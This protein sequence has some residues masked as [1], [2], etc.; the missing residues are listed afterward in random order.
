MMVNNDRRMVDVPVTFSHMAA[1]PFPYPSD[2]ILIFEEWFYAML[3]KGEERHRIYLPIFWTG[4]YI[5]AD[6]GKNEALIQMLQDY[7]NILDKSKKYYTIVQYDDGI[8][9]DLSGLDIRVFAMSGR[10]IDYPLPMICQPHEYKFNVERDIF[11]SFVG[12][13]T[14]TLREKIIAEFEDRPACYVTSR[15]HTLKDYCHVMARSVF[16][17]CPRGYGPTSFRIME[18]LQYGAIPV[19]M[20]DLL[21][22][23]HHH[24]F[25]GVGIP[26]TDEFN[27]R[28]LLSALRNMPISMERLRTD[29]PTIFQKCYTYEGTKAL[30]LENL[31]H[32]NIGN[33]IVS[34]N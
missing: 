25:P 29:I 1:H 22:F 23:G 30:I 21:I 24:Q 10:R 16:A 27:P 4:Y 11:M 31:Y 15:R 32:E 20:S 12:R 14:H 17:L 2:N 9:N 5:R 26:T 13:P 18:A 3:S 7:I 34:A 28:G 19:Y 8:L 33:D 6:Y